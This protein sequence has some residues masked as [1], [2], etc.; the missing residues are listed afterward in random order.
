MELEEPFKQDRK[1]LWYL[2]SRDIKTNR[3]RFTEINKNNDKRAVFYTINGMDDYIIKDS[4][5]YPYFFNRIRNL[6]LLKNLVEK[7]KELPKVDF[8]FAYYKD[9]GVL[10]GIVM[11]YYQDAESLNNLIKL[12]SFHEFQDFYHHDNNE[13]D[14]IIDL[15]LEIL[16]LISNMYDKGIFYMDIRPGNFVIYNNSVKVIDFE[17]G[18]VYF[19]DCGSWNYYQMLISYATL[20]ETVLCKFGFKNVLFNSGE[21]FF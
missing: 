5:E 1:G 6:K 17:P 9:Y 21:D 13:I 15:F 16:E 14:N 11:K 19:R 8:P 4:T 7:Q 2:D 10:R 20:V 18:F 3:K 12:Y